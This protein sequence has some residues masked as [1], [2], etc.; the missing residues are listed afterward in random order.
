MPASL[1]P[2]FS[3]AF[4]FQFRR[5]IFQPQIANIAPND[6]DQCGG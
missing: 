2:L 6:S 5:P 4:Q 1:L 3:S